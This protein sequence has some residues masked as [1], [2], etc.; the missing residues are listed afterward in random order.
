V[1]RLEVVAEEILPVVNGVV[2]TR[3]GSV[4][5]HEACVVTLAPAR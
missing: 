3:V 2:E 4:K 1:P 5:L